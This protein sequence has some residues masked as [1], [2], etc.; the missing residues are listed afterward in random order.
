MY[1]GEPYFRNIFIEQA[2]HIMRNMDR[3]YTA[4]LSSRSSLYSIPVRQS[5]YR[6]PLSSIKVPYKSMDKIP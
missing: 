4:N 5:W 6:D 1:I 2:I 3:I